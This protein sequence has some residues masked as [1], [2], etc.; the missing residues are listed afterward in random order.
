MPNIKPVSDLRNYYDVLSEVHEDAP[1]YL[2]K[3]GRGA[4]AIVT[5]EEYEQYER[6]KAS[7]E[8]FYEIKKALDI[9]EKEGVLTEEEAKKALGL[10]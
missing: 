5:M 8:L 1:V 10:K 7:M 2:T 6:L 4:Y 3:N 9:D